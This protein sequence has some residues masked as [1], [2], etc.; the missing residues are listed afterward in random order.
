MP[1]KPQPTKLY[2]V[3]IMYCRIS[4]LSWHI[5][6]LCIWPGC[7]PQNKLMSVNYQSQHKSVIMPTPSTYH[8]TKNIQTA[9]FS[10]TQLAII[11]CFIP[12]KSDKGSNFSQ[13]PNHLSSTCSLHNSRQLNPLVYLL[14]HPTSWSSTLR[15]HGHP[16][17]TT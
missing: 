14:A 17:Q 9:R 16:K 6:S 3:F 1:C 7:L 15:L 4:V 5:S 10:H 2:K 13:S 8:G 11:S 12:S